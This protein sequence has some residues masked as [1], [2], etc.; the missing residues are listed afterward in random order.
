MHAKTLLLT[1]TIIVCLASC[2]NN[3]SRTPISSFRETKKKFEIVNKALVQKDKERILAYIER[4]K[5]EGMQENKSG[6]YYLIWG[7]K[8]GNKV[9]E[10]DIVLINYKIELLDGTLCYNTFTENTPK[11]FM[12]SKGGVEAGLE[13]AI[14][15]M[16]Q[17]QKGKFIMPPHLAHGLLGDNDKIPPMAILVFDVE[18]LSVIES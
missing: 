15:L 9:K 7:E 12:V 13:L 5:L 4:H 18:L 3:N 8:I 10:G 16:H 17:G 2:K 6:L 11:E 14:L 1:I